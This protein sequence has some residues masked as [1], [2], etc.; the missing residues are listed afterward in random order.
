MSHLMARDSTYHDRNAVCIER[1]WPLHNLMTSSSQLCHSIIED[2]FDWRMYS[3]NAVV[4]HDS[5]DEWALREVVEYA[6]LPR[7]WWELCIHGP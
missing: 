4:G 6:L 2:P 5:N 1:G 7:H 3:N